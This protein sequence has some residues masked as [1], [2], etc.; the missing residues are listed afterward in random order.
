MQ[1][2]NAGIHDGLWPSCQN[3]VCGICCVFFPIRGAVKCVAMKNLKSVWQQILMTFERSGLCCDT[4]TQNRHHYFPLRV[5]FLYSNRAVIIDCWSYK[6]F[7]LDGLKLRSWNRLASP[8]VS[9]LFIWP[10]VAAVSPSTS[11]PTVLGHHT[12]SP[13][14][15]RSDIQSSASSHCGMAEADRGNVFVCVHKKGCVFMSF[16]VCVPEWAPRPVAAL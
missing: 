14:Y 2:L 11:T 12:V 1:I 9:G 3:F 10:D 15:V 5:H 16:S 4:R 7:W 13:H 6:S 8:H